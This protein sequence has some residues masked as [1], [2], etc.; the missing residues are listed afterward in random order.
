[1]L[2]LSH[3]ASPTT[4]TKLDTFGAALFGRLLYSAC[5]LWKFVPKVLVDTTIVRLYSTRR[6]GGMEGTCLLASTM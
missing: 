1:M 4:N 3:K 2:G 5:A 6:F